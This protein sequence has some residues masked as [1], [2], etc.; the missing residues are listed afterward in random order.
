MIAVVIPTYNEEALISRVLGSLAMQEVNEPLEIVVADNMSRDRTRQI[1]ETF[2]K[3]FA[4]FI[5]VEGGTP[6][7]GRNRGAYASHGDPIFFLDAD[8]ELC[9]PTFIDQN[10][11]YF[12]LHRL[13]AASVRLVPQS[14][15]WVDHAMVKVYNLLLSAAVPFRPLGSMCIVVSRFTFERTGGYPEEVAM[16]E[17]HDFVLRCSKIGRYRIL[18][19]RAYFSIRRLEK[20]GRLLL[21][22]KYIRAFILRIFCGPITAFDYEFGYP[23]E[24]QRHD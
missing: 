15:K 24:D 10:V 21:V 22:V 5:I 19:M 8:L 12:R 11:N 2:R 13:A 1:A 4:R 7:V 14:E 23:Q 17:D 3:R 18:P 6:A 20:E 9:D 16:E